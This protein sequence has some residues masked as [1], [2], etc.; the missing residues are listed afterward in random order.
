MKKIFTVEGTHCPACKA[1]IE[2]VCKDINGVKSCSVDFKTGKTIIKYDEKL[3]LNLV[4]RE[5][6]ALGGYKVEV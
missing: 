4:K 6:E 3:D 5:I 1:L 2:D